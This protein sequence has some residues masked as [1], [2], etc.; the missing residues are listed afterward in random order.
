M[1]AHD[2]LE[3]EGDDVVVDCVDLDADMVRVKSY[4]KPCMRGPG[5]AQPCVSARSVC[6]KRS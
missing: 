2:K 1:H 3:R 5:P 4:P 6:F